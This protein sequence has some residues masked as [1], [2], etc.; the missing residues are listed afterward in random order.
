V[1][2]L[3]FSCSVNILFCVYYIPFK[4]LSLNERKAT[5]VAEEE[6]KAHGRIEIRKVVT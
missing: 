2:N 5:D 1:Q 6:E 4:N 3:V